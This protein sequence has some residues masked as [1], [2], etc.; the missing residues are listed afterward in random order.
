MAL[1]KGPRSPRS[2][3]TPETK[4]FPVV[5]PAA[6]TPDRGATLNL[7]N[8][9]ELVKWL[10]SNAEG[11]KKSAA[12]DLETARRI[13]ADA[14]DH[15]RH[16]KEAA[17][18]EMALLGQ[19]E[20]MRKQIDELR[21]VRESHTQQKEM[22]ATEAQQFADR[23]KGFENHA[24]DLHAL[25]TVTQQAQA[26][27]NSQPPAVTAPGIELD[28]KETARIDASLAAIDAAHAELPADQRDEGEL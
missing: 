11:F 18:K 28:P 13:Y 8:P 5:S 27:G 21:N 6:P 7:Q 4:P 20:D 24:A 14:T 15:E 12:E 1:T 22:R 9:T 10:S 19:L 26:N 25:I 17:D 23:A 3:K 16:E 2:R